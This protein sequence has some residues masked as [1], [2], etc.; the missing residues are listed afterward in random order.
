[1]TTHEDM[2]RKLAESVLGRGGAIALELLKTYALAAGAEVLGGGWIRIPGQFTAEAQGWRQFAVRVQ[3]YG[4]PWESMRLKMARAHAEGE[5]A[6]RVV[7][8]PPPLGQTPVHAADLNPVA[9]PAAEALPEYYAARMAAT[10]KQ[11]ALANGVP[12]DLLAPPPVAVLDP[13]DVHIG[14]DVDLAD[15]SAGQEKI[16]G[17][18]IKRTAYETGKALLDVLEGWIEGQQ[19][20]HEA[21]GH[22]GENIGEECWSQYHPE[23]IRRMVNDAMRLM[24]AP[25]HRLPQDGE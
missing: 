23:D 19:E 21:S 9:A 1:M 11:L 22:R 25:E 16:V 14:D 7:T 6:M 15:L 10:L 18:I 8:P 4:G 17:R 12:L 13:R 5:D 2:I 20:N 24:G 3:D